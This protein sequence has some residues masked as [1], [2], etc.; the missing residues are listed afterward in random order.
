M[1]KKTTTSTQ[2]NQKDVPM[3]E[4]LGRAYSGEKASA[5]NLAKNLPTIRQS[6]PPIE[7]SDGYEQV[8]L[9]A[10]AGNS[11][12]VGL[13]VKFRKGH[14]PVGRDEGDLLGAILL[15]HQVQVAWQK[16]YDMRPVG[17]IMQRPGEYFPPSVEK[18]DDPDGGPGEWQLTAFLYLR[19]LEYGHD[20]TFTASSFGGRRAV[21]NL[22][23]QTRNM[24]YLRLGCLPVVKLVA[25]SFRSA[26]YGVIDCPVFPVERWI[27]SGDGG[28]ELLE[29]PQ[30]KK[31]NPDTSSGAQPAGSLKDE[32]DDDLSI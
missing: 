13:P 21:D 24:R 27:S 32:L 22:V 7:P 25:S 29:Q 16:W 1:A 4:N 30:P 10:T 5:E 28:R 8:D 9:A 11:P 18:I 19:D 17:L 12:I 6:E 14:F 26:K 3:T 31:P 15:A 2:S 20:Y 23:R